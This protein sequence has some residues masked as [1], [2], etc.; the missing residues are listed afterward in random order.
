MPRLKPAGYI[1]VFLLITGTV[2]LILRFT[3]INLRRLE[4]HWYDLTN[5]NSYVTER[6]QI[7][8]IFSGFKKIRLDDIPKGFRVPAGMTKKDYRRA[9]KGH[10]WFVLR[11]ADLYKKIAGSNRLMSL[12]SSDN[13][14]RH[15]SLFSEKEFY[16]DLDIRILYRFLEIQDILEKNGLDRNAVTIISGHRT[17]QHNSSVGG[18]RESR[19]LNGDAIDIKIGDLNKDGSTD[20]KDKKLLIPVLEKVIGNRGGVGVYTMSVHIDLR[21]RRSRW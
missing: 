15:E 20:K 12:V 4:M 6:G 1:L 5:Q 3:G 16:L 7:Q 9:M 2:F 10:T 19:H 8:E 14:Y 18:K 11:K 17:P 13:G 21:G